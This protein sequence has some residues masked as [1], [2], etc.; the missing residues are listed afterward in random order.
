MAA[1]AIVGFLS[2]R[3]L[4]AYVRV[5]DYRPFAFYRF[6]LAGVTLLVLLARLR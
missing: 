5:R 6:A 4:L 2:I 1:A 3:F